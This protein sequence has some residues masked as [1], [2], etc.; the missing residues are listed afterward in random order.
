MNKIKKTT[1]ESNET[2]P[3]SENRKEYGQQPK[4]EKMN[5]I[6]KQ[7]KKKMFQN[8]KKTIDKKNGHIWPL[9]SIFGSGGG[10]FIP[11]KIK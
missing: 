6:E 1:F 10:F 7:N 5:G 9:I 11:E 8:Q 3:Q 4:K 2:E